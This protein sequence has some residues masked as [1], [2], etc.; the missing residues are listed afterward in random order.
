MRQQTDRLQFVGIQFS[1][2][3]TVLRWVADGDSLE[4]RR[5][6]ADVA[7]R[8]VDE[9]LADVDHDQVNG[10]IRELIRFDTPAACSASPPPTPWR[11]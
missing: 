8:A 1:S 10:Q 3:R 9:V 11:N 7:K 2:L 6:R 5:R 4:E